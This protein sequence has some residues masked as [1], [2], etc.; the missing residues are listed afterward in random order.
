MAVSKIADV[1]VP[2]VY[3]DYFMENS[4]YKSALWRSG[5]VATNEE[6]KALLLGGAKTF[7]MPFWQTNDV[8]GAS[9]TPVDEDQTLTP[10]SLTADKMIA[11]RQFREK[12]WGQNDVAAVLA[13][14]APIDG[15]MEATEKFWNRNYQVVL[16]KSVQGVI[17][18]NVANDSSDLVNDITGA[19]VTTIN[20]DAVIDTVALFGDADQDIAA[21]AMHSAPYNQLRKLNMIDNRPDNEQNIGWG[22]YLGKTV[23]V[24]DD[25]VVS[26]VYWT[27]LFKPGAFAYAEVLEGANYEPTE[28]D[29]DPA[30]SGG[31]TLY[32]TRRVFLMHPAG[33]AYSDAA[34]VDS[35]TDAELA[36]AAQWNRVAA[37][38]KNC[39]FAVLKSSG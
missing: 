11:C 21:I 23:I 13:G 14:D 7:N 20:S 8:I 24:D 33:F 17:A 31:Q 1:V 32:Y 26:S 25:L 6:M 10:G 35:P 5:M 36:G 18:D 29:R 39:G 19:S 3:N 34:S 30:K 38:V 4:I 27:I 28:V 12:A 22:T 15:M 9:A 2:E 37:S 16:F